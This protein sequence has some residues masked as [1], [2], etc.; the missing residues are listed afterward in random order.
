MYI[1]GAVALT[2]GWP[3]LWSGF[4]EGHELFHRPVLIGAVWHFVCIYRYGT[5]PLCFSRRCAVFPQAHF[6]GEIS[7]RVDIS[8]RL[9]PPLQAIRSLIFSI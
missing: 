1:I 2:A 8:P 3:V 4:I 9:I 7:H 6:S 5:H